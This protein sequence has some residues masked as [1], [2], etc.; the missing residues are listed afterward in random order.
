MPVPGLTLSAV[1]SDPVAVTLVADTLTATPL[2]DEVDERTSSGW[3]LAS[4]W[5]ADILR[6]GVLLDGKPGGLMASCSVWKSLLG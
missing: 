2:V 6:G 1:L 4:D 3:V 5:A